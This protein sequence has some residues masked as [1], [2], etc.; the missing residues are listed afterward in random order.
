MTFPSLFEQTVLFR[1]GTRYEYGD[2]TIKDHIVGFTAEK[3]LNQT[4]DENEPLTDDQKLACLSVQ[5]AL[6]F[7]PYTADVRQKELN[8]IENHL[9]VCSNLPM[10]F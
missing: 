7:D 6:N 8:L 1:F 2:A 5:L 9:Q 4:P 3:L 10:L